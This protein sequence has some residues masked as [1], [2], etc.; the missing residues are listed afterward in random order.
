VTSP[1]RKGVAVV[2]GAAG[3][4][5]AAVARTLADAGFCVVA[6]DLDADAGERVVD[7]IAATRGSAVFITADV[8]S[9]EAVERVRGLAVEQGSVRALVNAAAILRCNTVVDTAEAEWDEVMAVNVRGTYLMCRAMV[10][11]IAEAGGGAV[12]NISSVHAVA[13]VPRLAAY[14]AS[15][16]AIL[17]L[18][19]QMALDYA[20]EGIRVIPLVVGSVDTEMSRQHAA[21]QGL[22][23]GVWDPKDRSAGRMAAPD[24]VARVVAFAVSDAASFL[25]G[26]PLVVDGG[27]LARL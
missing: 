23:P 10:P 2:T 6:C 25:N 11:A 12:V 3:G 4:I 24:E 15:K 5:G 13:T 21:A 8:R 9:S 19:R 16:G 20:E 26:S 14:A 7:Q 17:A 27:L 22:E 1:L 18:S